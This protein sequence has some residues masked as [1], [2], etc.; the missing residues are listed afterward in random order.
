MNKG[1]RLYSGRKL[2][3]LR[4]D[5][6]NP[7]REEFTHTQDLGDRILTD[8]WT[9]KEFKHEQETEIMKKKNDQWIQTSPVIGIKFR[10][11]K[12][13]G[14]IFAYLENKCIGEVPPYDTYRLGTQLVNFLD[15]FREQINGVHKGI[16]YTELQLK[17]WRKIKIEKGY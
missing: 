12:E 1:S 9:A 10:K 14:R 7:R 8:K 11:S 5:K 16:R 15:G 2:Q 17:S 4:I 13:T 6:K 3:P